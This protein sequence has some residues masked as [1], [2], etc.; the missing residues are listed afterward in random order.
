MHQKHCTDHHESSKD[1]TPLYLIT[2]GR[3]HHKSDIEP[4]NANKSP[5][6]ILTIIPLLEKDF[7]SNLSNL[8]TLS[9]AGL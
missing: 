4:S 3:Y 8:M 7:R 1:L 6:I 5:K 9:K 2:G